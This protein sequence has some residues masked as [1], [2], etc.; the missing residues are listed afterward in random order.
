MTGEVPSRI[1]RIKQ[2][3]TMRNAKVAGGM[4]V[5][6][7]FGAAGA[8]AYERSQAVETV[9]ASPE[10]IVRSTEQETANNKR[11]R[12]REA[13][14]GQV[15]YGRDAME[16][17]Q[18]DAIPLTFLGKA[19]FSNPALAAEGSSVEITTPIIIA[20]QD[21]SSTS[22]Q[23]IPETLASINAQYP[24]PSGIEVIDLE[25][26][27]SYVMQL[28][29]YDGNPVDRSVLDTL[30]AAD[31]YEN[32]YVSSEPF[33]LQTTADGSYAFMTDSGR[34]VGEFSRGQ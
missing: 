30:Y 29:D 19:V 3:F 12:N 20:R 2:K 31:N 32:Q 8:T 1:E 24:Y 25:G 33:S 23:L 10:H 21:G 15:I 16:R 7:W 9:Q 34:V 6:A 11:Q 26:A 17:H 18:F 27:G 4:L 28:F 13:V 5:A 22:P 14:F